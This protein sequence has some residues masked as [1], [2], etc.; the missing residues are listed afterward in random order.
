MFSVLKKVRDPNL[1][2]LE[3][4]LEKTVIPH[5]KLDIL[6][7]LVFFYIY[8]NIHKAEI[9][10]K[11]Q[12]DL[13]H[14]PANKEHLLHY[15]LNYASFKNQLYQ[16]AS[17]R[18]YYLKTIELVEE[19]GDISQIIEVYID[20]SGT[21]LNLGQLD[22]AQ[23]F[24]EKSIKYLQS[25][26]NK[27][28]EFR[29]KCRQGFLCLSN[30]QYEQALGFLLESEEILHQIDSEITIKDIHFLAQVYSNMGM[31]Y[32]IIDDKEKCIRAYQ[33][34]VD[35]CEAESINTRISFHY[36]NLGKIFLSTDDYTSAEAYFKKALKRN[37][38]ISKY[39]RM[40][41]LANLGY[42][43]YLKG[44]FEDALRCYHSAEKL[45]QFNEDDDQTIIA[46]IASFKAK[47]YLTLG[48]TKKAEK[49]L[50]EALNN[51]TD[52][53]DLKLMI[54]INQD[55]AT[56]YSDIGD[57]RN[58]YQYQKQHSLYA[59]QYYE[60]LHGS[61]LSELEAKYRSE[62]RENEV[63]MLRLQATML[64]GRALRAQMNPHF[65]YNALNSIQ[66][67]ITTDESETA[68]RYLAQFARLMRQSLNNSD[69]ES[70]SLENDID[71]LY[72]YLS[73]NQKLRFGDNLKFEIEVDEEIEED[74]MNVPA[75]IVQPYVENAIEH[76]LR[77]KNGGLIRIS[78]TM[79]NDNVIK[80]VVE[81]D[82]V[83]RAYTSI[84]KKA[85]H[86]FKDHQ[87]MGTNITEKRLSILHQG[88]FD[89]DTF[90]K[91]IDLIDETTGL[92]C[93]TRVE[94]LIPVLEVHVHKIPDTIKK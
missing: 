51:L 80:C 87:S 72:N 63:Q 75:M 21:L 32:E 4:K 49:Q 42:C 56:F 45:H 24:I 54:S 17:A 47:L 37:E 19:F 15:Y 57:F 82:G 33:R 38:D 76:G 13:V 36:N 66:H 60:A 5:Q 26:P 68:T 43:Y 78:Y 67:F 27:I 65:I 88:Q 40:G 69:T 3:Q 1:S 94:I 58:A 34:A 77:P 74:I 91:T 16:Y 90:V 48:K 53:K 79:V 92:P 22:E 46:Q 25:F 23:S 41:A 20:Y 70:I 81:D 83:G 59:Q 73:L 30:H 8:K 44:Q 7:D 39:S 11:H 84:I 14:D 62:K 6:K 18:E 93:G 29:T 86:N 35:F 28:L 85:D 64:Q 12:E 71:F 50:V 2:Y 61:K 10:L 31:I 55:I 9:F 89:S 52:S